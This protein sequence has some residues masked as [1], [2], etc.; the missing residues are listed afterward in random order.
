M[1]AYQEYRKIVENRNRN[2]VN[3]TVSS[4]NED[5]DI[6]EFR[7][8]KQLKE[9][10]TGD[11]WDE[12][13]EKLKAYKAIDDYKSRAE[14]ALKLAQTRLL[15][16]SEGVPSSYEQGIDQYVRDR[17]SGAEQ[18]ALD[19]QA[20]DTLKSI[21]TSKM[22]SISKGAMEQALERIRG[23]VTDA[24]EKISSAQKDIDKEQSKYKTPYDYAYGIT[25]EDKSLEEKLF[26]Y[27]T[28]LDY[29]GKTSEYNK[30]EEPENKQESIMD[31]KELPEVFKTNQ[32]KAAELF[33]PIYNPLLRGEKSGISDEENEQLLRQR[34]SEKKNRYYSLLSRENDFDKYAAKGEQSEDNHF[35]QT[36][37]TKKTEDIISAL[38]GGSTIGNTQNV[39]DNTIY[40]YKTL[41]YINDDEKKTYNYILGKYG[42]EKATD[43]L[44][45]LL[46]TLNY[47]E[48]TERAENIKGN[49][50]RELVSAVGNA[51]NIIDSGHK[52]ANFITG[53]KALPPSAKE[54][55]AAQIR[56][57]LAD[58]GPKIINGSSLG[59]AAYDLIG[60]TANM[61]PYMALGAGI[62]SAAGATAGNI[63]S[64]AGLGAGA[65]VDTANR[66][67]SDGNSKGKSLAYG[68]LN[69]IL[70]GGLQYAIGGISAFGGKLTGITKDV[71]AG[72]LKSTAGKALAN[73]G[74]TASSEGIEEYL[75][76][77]LDPAVRNLTLGE[78]NE[79]DFKSKDA[80]YAGFLGA[81][82][83]ITMGG[84]SDVYKAKYDT[85]LQ[86]EGV[87]AL[88]SV[89][90]DGKTD[91]S[92]AVDYA[93]EAVNIDIEDGIN[94][95]SEM[96]HAL[97]N[98]NAS[99]SEISAGK[100]TT[101][102][103]RYV[104]TLQNDYDG[105]VKN[106]ILT[107]IGKDEKDKGNIDSLVDYA[108]GI[109]ELKNYAKEYT[110]NQ[111]EYSAGK[112]KSEVDAYVGRKVI[113]SNDGQAS[114]DSIAES[115]NNVITAIADEALNDIG[116]IEQN[117]DE[118]EI[119]LTDNKSYY[120]A[121]VNN[122]KIIESFSDGA[123]KVMEDYNTRTDEAD[124]ADYQNAFADYYQ[125][126]RLGLSMDTAEQNVTY[127]NELSNAE[128]NLAYQTGVNDRVNVFKEADTAASVRKNKGVGV[129]RNI[130]PE[131]MTEGITLPSKLND[132][133][134][135][136]RNSVR[137]LMRVAEVTG[138]NYVI[139]SSQPVNGQVTA[140]NGWYDSAKDT[141]YVDVNSGNIGEQAVLRTA[142]HEITHMLREWSPERY[143][144][145]QDFVIKQYESDGTIMSLIDNQ[146]KKAGTNGTEIS[147]EGALDEVT[148]DAC[149]MMLK[150]SKAAVRLADEAPET[151]SKIKQFI[152]DFIF[153]IKAAFKGVK[154]T[155]IEY[156][157]LKEILDDWTG[158]QKLWDDAFIEASERANKAEKV[159]GAKVKSEEA[160][161]SLRDT[162]FNKYIDE[163][164]VDYYEKV[165]QNTDNINDFYS[166]SK[167]IPE[168]L[169][170]DIYNV[171]G[172]KLDFRKCEN[173]IRQGQIKHIENDHGSNGT[174][175]KSMKDK[176]NI[177]IIN[178]I[179]NNYTEY[180]EGKGTRAFRNIDNTR[181]KTI[182]ISMKINNKMYYVIEAVPNNK[183]KDK[184]YVI[185]A[186]LGNKN[187]AM[188]VSDVKKSPDV[189]PNNVLANAITEKITQLDDNVNN[190]IKQN[191]AYDTLGNNLTKEQQKNFSDSK[192]ID[193]N[194]RY[195]IRGSFEDQVDDVIN[196]KGNYNYSHVLVKENTPEILT[197]L[198]GIPDFPVLMTSKHVY[199]T[200]VSEQQA[201]QEGKYRASDKDNY[202]D[203]GDILKDVPDAIENP[204][205]I[206]KS[207]T[208]NN[209]LRFIMI[210]DIKDK[211]N[212][213]VIVALK[214][215][216]KGKIEK[217]Y[218]DANIV[219]SVYGREIK[220]H[221][222]TALNEDRILY[223]DKTRSQDINLNPGLQLASITNNLDFTNNLSQYK[224]I[225]NN[226]IYKNSKNDNINHSYRDDTHSNRELLADALMEA[227][228]TKAERQNLEA[229][230]KTIGSLDML[231]KLMKEKKKAM[232]N[233][234]DAATRD[235][236]SA[237][238]DDLKKKINFNDRKLLELEATKP[239]KD[240]IN[241]EAHEQSR[242]KI[243]ELKGT[244]R[245]RQINK[246][247]SVLR[248]RIKENV[249]SIVSLLNNPDKK[250]HVP[251][252]LKED[253]TDF[254]TAFNY[255]SDKAQP[256]SWSTVMWNKKMDQLYKKIN[257]INETG[258][259]DTNGKKIDTDIHFDPDLLTSMSEFVKNNEGKRISEFGTKELEDMYL[260]VRSLRMGI[261]NANTMYENKRSE[262]AEKIGWGSIQDLKDLKSRKLYGRAMDLMNKLINTDM[263]DSRS[264]FKMLGDNSFTIYEELRSGWNKKTLD[265]KK[266]QEFLENIKKELGIKEK[267]IKA[268]SDEIHDFM[269]DGK[270]L[271]VTT[272]QLMSLYE[273]RKRIQS[274][275]HITGVGV[276][277]ED[278]K[279]GG[280]NYK[281][282][283]PV[284]LNEDTIT[285]MTSKLSKEQIDFA[286]ALQ[287]YMSQE[288]A[289]QMNETSMKLYGYRKFT[290]PNYFPIDTDKNSVRS[291]DKTAADT[292]GM[293]EIINM[294][295]TKNLVEN[296]SNA[297]ILRDIFDVYSDHVVDA[298]NYHGM[299]AP[300]LDANRW[301]NYK[302]QEGAVFESVKQ[303]IQRVHGIQFQN[304]YTKLIQDI[305]GDDGRNDVASNISDVLMKGTKTA[306]IGL[307]IRVVAQQPTAYFRAMNV[308][309]SKYL[310]KALIPKGNAKEAIENS[311]IAYWKTQGYYETS[312]GKSLKQTITGIDSTREK[313]IEKTLYL[314]GKAD[315]MTWGH[316]WNAC[317]YEVADKYK[318]LDTGSEEFMKK[319]TERFEEVIDETQVVDTV[320]HR[321]QIMRSKNKL[322]NMATLFMSEPLKSYNMLRNAIV[323]KDKK[324]IFRAF[325][326]YIITN[327]INAAVQSVIDACRAA[328]R[329]DEREKEW[330]ERW[331]E[332][333]QG[334]LIN[335]L[336]PA[337]IIPY[338]NSICNVIEGWKTERLDMA[339][340]ESSV[341][342]LKELQK[343]FNG[344]MRPDKLV[345]KI[346][347][348]ASQATGIGFSNLQKDIMA[349]VNT[350]KYDILQGETYKEKLNKAA[351]ARMSGDMNTYKEIVMGL[352]GGGEDLDE[353]IKDVNRD[354]IKEKKKVSES[355]KNQTTG[356]VEN[357]QNKEPE[358]VSLYK[359]SDIGTVLTDDIST[360][361]DIINE[362]YENALS[363]ADKTKKKYKYETFKLERQR[364][365]TV[366][367]RQYKSIEDKEE[368][369]K[370]AKNM[371][372]LRLA[373]QVLYEFDD[374]LKL[375]KSLK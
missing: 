47:R 57:D 13:T 305:N 34:E 22:D 45:D 345:T 203:L 298:A 319:V 31:K 35:R 300:I 347:A 169:A 72:K 361:Q 133:S 218:I 311:P 232:N 350:A 9:N 81:F 349:V 285:M 42:K 136:Q 264:Y 118:D 59:Q 337:K 82:S 200:S 109:K 153:K 174:S 359:E 92:K 61:V 120:Q 91:I 147:R 71:V 173:R 262:N 371:R 70:E 217:R 58:K 121:P 159:D 210:T 162:E 192:V 341:D 199:T 368:R 271:K 197:E 151:Y 123:R 23:N 356:S 259:I 7:K 333:F 49:T 302:Y 83:G 21:R 242:Q 115:G 364:I 370:Y 39:S 77:V 236:Y 27:R 17:I 80:L 146:V 304:Y 180:R 303:E 360:A 344:E 221:I 24:S 224:K 131:E 182:E 198:L 367:S 56:E 161:F 324:L 184:I 306:A 107:N 277:T 228:K 168:K 322:V 187:K 301:F 223:Y 114:R 254:V 326:T 40:D 111:D 212:R 332:K 46:T 84:V 331:I 226:I 278:F 41:E 299:A 330:T 25:G 160:V 365:K 328:N 274:M 8:Y 209:D 79:V 1:G 252:Q 250:R 297:L 178:Y 124:S 204:V 353:V 163:N 352:K 238:I 336:N 26:R 29:N 248:G 149:E 166:I 53:E 342:L 295:A 20:D 143:K 233:A 286:D 51:T 94:K 93:T 258:G 32:Q 155:S 102:V 181:S 244:Y 105:K 276:K 171:T 309:D 68:T 351:V 338:V 119:M 145:L 125:Y 296:A 100:L 129:V 273:H 137:A 366:I 130:R 294:G 363:K 90:A 99:P 325:K 11:W 196:N 152:K 16:T 172:I 142:S 157:H 108:S 284:Q 327:T 261:N 290:D 14:G 348:V 257:E 241:R 313:I 343:T 48:G 229:Y 246:Q 249:S 268:W 37:D 307:N 97:K 318:A 154:G 66:A 316:I 275:G 317:K 195:S 329:D 240:V 215:S 138:Q 60:N 287:E 251:E 44:D 116:F 139:Y 211:Q 183:T 282:D 208:D 140:P 165:I 206:I 312:I 373:K 63:A 374:I 234:T 334:N 321:T 74:I 64:A 144:S 170:D 375:E 141:I 230:K 243:E 310:L 73:L 355:V 5:E 320:F 148:A 265:I 4:K 263:L 2:S 12:R 354:M 103:A 357:K 358:N 220:K 101:E 54:I 18:Y 288:C 175:D 237:E 95:S 113:D 191:S 185:S 52:L 235:R 339:V 167:Q 3:S 10:N 76:E 122:N 219:L 6:S 134:I 340:V 315:E 67:W 110:D 62:G 128:K 346:V 43:Y 239:L 202:H 281:N 177:G 323:T 260:I 158:I 179:L 266:S 267:D 156:T 272:T 132:M 89:D 227:A 188:Q 362:L 186:Y 314:A 19:K 247:N 369:M 86:Q 213:S 194:I 269:I 50:A 190:P 106:E 127:Q 255:I 78:N 270:S 28:G 222:H 280:K 253:V 245:Q 289:D 87:K 96:E 75:Q 112:L 85:Y 189:T 55:A 256:D 335:N 176:S 69:G 205:M 193:E 231:D 279:A 38:T 293:Y 216:G 372:K 30:Y 214:P 283:Y 135:R 126:G 207:N 98:Y 104:K 291:S 36:E 15:H 65:G 292:A 117:T 150:D 164:L 225:V 88:N 201:K 33:K 308:I